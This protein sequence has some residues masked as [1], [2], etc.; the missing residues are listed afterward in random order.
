MVIRDYLLG[1]GRYPIGHQTVDPVI[2]L[3][4]SADQP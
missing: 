2:V 1:T 4:G 3:D